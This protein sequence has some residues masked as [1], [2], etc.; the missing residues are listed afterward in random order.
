LRGL[1]IYSVRVCAKRSEDHRRG[2][3]GEQLRL[4]TLRGHAAFLQLAES[5]RR[6]PQSI[7]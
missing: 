2:Q 7:R 5:P 3:R 6:R 4:F 1:P